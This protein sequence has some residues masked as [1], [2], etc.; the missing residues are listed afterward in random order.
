MTISRSR[1]ALLAVPALCALAPLAIHGRAFAADAYPRGP[2]RLIVPYAP[3]GGTDATAR[4]VAKRLGER[5]GGTFV[6]ENR[7]GGNT[8]IGTQ[9]L[10][11]AAPDGYVLGMFNAAGPIN[12]AI[13]PAL[14]YDVTRDFTPITVIVRSAGGLW[15]N[16]S[17]IPAR[18]FDELVAW[19]RAH[20]GTAYASSGVG[21][22]N[23]L[24]ME[25]FRE[26]LG[27]DL[28]HVPFKGSGEAAVAVASGEVPMSVDS[29]GPM[30][31]HWQAGRVLP[32]ATT[33]DERYPLMPDVPTFEELGHPEL[34]GT[35]AWWGIA[36]PKGLPPEI[37]TRLREEI[38]AILREP[39]VV[40]ALLAVG[41][42]PAPIGGED[43]QQLLE[44]DLAKW[45]AVVA[46]GAVTQ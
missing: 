16:T 38:H 20:P 36:G 41:A 43:F 5:M 37:A 40:Q 27:L 22:A 21:A 30:E 14:P 15:V 17:R 1:R 11:Q 4:L 2:V 28:L 46:R 18:N 29:F 13:D 35:S 19:L 24:S 12:Q 9:A 10:K 31:P 32:V 7:A 34:R 25:L 23:H 45:K 3:G 42:V 39:E 33:G 44:S 6:V 26:S 8:R